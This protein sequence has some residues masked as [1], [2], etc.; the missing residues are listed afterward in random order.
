VYVVRVRPA[1][2]LAA[3]PLPTLGDPLMQRTQPITHLLARAR[4]GDDGALDELF[5]LVY[6]VLRGTARRELRR[7]SAC[8]TLSTTDLIHE[9]YLKLAPGTTVAWVDR[10]HF[11]RV[12]A[13]AMR[14]VLIDRARRRAAD[15]RRH[16]RLRLTQPAAATGL[17]TSWHEL[18]ALDAALRRLRA[19]DERLHEVVELRFFGGL[20]EAETAAAL[21]VSARTVRR[22]WTKARLFLHREMHPDGVPA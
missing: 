11:L 10:A 16:E 2:I 3:G 6:E 12:A 13:R 17:P 14:Q 20:S 9:A 5:P 18:L 7:G 21:G 22:D 1:C 8:V 15:R 19:L 4:R